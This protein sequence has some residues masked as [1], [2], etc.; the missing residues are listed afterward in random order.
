[1]SICDS[2]VIVG[3]YSW[4][5][6]TCAC[7]MVGC[8]FSAYVKIWRGVR[9]DLNNFSGKNNLSLFEQK[10]RT[11]QFNLNSFPTFILKLFMETGTNRCF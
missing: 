1:M 7:K 10:A 5:I 8:L 3:I 11:Y 2:M 6:Q 4:P 9:Y